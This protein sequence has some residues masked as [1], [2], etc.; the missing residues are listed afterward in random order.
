MLCAW[1]GLLLVVISFWLIS[2]PWP[3]ESVA[4]KKDLPKENSKTEKSFWSAPDESTI[5]SD[6]K[7]ELIRYGKELISHTA[8]YL[9][10]NGKIAHVS[11]GMNCQNCHLKAGTVPFGNNY[12]GVA[13][14]YPKFRDRSGTIESVEKR[15][16]DCIERSLNGKTL[17]SA[18]KE[19]RAF[20][21]Y[22][23]WVGKDVPKKTNPKG[24]GL[25]D[26]KKLDRAIDPVKGKLVYEENCVRCHQANGEGL[27]EEN[28]VEWKYPPLWGKDSYNIGA[29]LFRMSRFAGYVKMN[30]PNDVASHEKPFLTDE[31]AWDVAAFVN[32]MP[33][34]DKDI[35][36]DWP[37]ISSKPFD[38]PFGP[39]ADGFSESQHKFGPFEPII[40]AKKKSK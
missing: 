35:S 18:S 25:F 15:V 32:S 28:S 38:H 21:S 7:G 1:V 23:T 6:E 24:V 40:A 31:Q 22:I 36:K 14:N 27:R 3:A 4:D 19:M 33:R 26:L 16:N 34:P 30:M 5:S 9:G 10:P 12:S 8:S 17:D 13:A 29:G 20:V 37:K 39:Y 11:N 2:K